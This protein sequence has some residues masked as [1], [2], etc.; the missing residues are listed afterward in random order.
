M[1][2]APV[3][4]FVDQ[5]VD[6]RGSTVTAPATG[7]DPTGV[8]GRR[9]VA[10][11]IDTVVVSAIA[12]ATFFATADA[13]EI[14]DARDCSDLDL[15]GTGR[16]CG[17][18]NDTVY[19]FEGRAVLFAG[20]ASLAWVLLIGW[21]VQGTTGATLGKAIAGVR[22]VDEQGRGPGLGKQAVRGLLWVVPDGL[23]T[24]AG[25]PIVAALTAGLTKGHRRVGDMAAKTFV[26]RSRDRG[27][28]VAVPG[29]TAPP[30]GF[31]A[32]APAP[33]AVPPPMAPP[34]GPPVTEPAPAE[35]LTPWVPPSTEPAP[36]AQPSPATQP[37]P[38]PAPTEPLTPWVPPSTEPAPP[39]EPGPA[40]APDP[41]PSPA[42]PPSQP[43]W[44]ATR[45]T[46]IVWD[47]AR[48]SWMAHDPS[49]GQWYPIS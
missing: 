40:P 13:T 41:T 45:Q 26:V 31:T 28:P 23:F 17:E 36:P 6:S 32:P 3:D 42:P 5:S 7:H 48:G 9:S 43:Q 1:M 34:M 37:T 11:V 14:V 15:S 27:T 18:L 19:V 35:P 20:L 2:T 49:S 4:Q 29:L 38:P 8:L 21:I 12:I 22:T 39:P 47:P 16:F 46:Y 10:Y 44:D 30:G 24:C 33:S 25:V